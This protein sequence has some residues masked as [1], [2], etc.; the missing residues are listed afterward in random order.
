MINRHICPYCG[1]LGK[2]QVVK[3]GTTLSEILLWCCLLFPGLVYTIWRQT[4]KR[5]R[6]P[7]CTTRRMIQ[8]KSELG[9]R[10]MKRFGYT[11]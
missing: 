6:C 2:P 11:E 8:I 5:S 3:P 4:L 7:N 9:Q 1:H 10:N